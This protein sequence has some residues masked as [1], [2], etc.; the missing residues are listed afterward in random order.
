MKLFQRQGG[1]PADVVERAE[2]PPGEKALAHTQAA[3]ATW[4]L[5][6]R[7]FLVIVPSGGSAHRI[8]WEQVEDAVWDQEAS[9]LRVTEI[10][11]YGEQ[12]PVYSFE[13]ERDPALFLQL[14]RERAL[15]SQ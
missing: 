1:V 2:L 6:T 9:R 14:L 4:V 8:P 12:R 3:D 15:E 7:R 10:G 11:S 5:G 13:V